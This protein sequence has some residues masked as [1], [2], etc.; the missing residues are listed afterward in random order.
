MLLSKESIAPI[1]ETFLFPFGG[2]VRV[3]IVLLIERANSH[4]FTETYERESISQRKLAERFR[5]APSF[6]YKLLKQYTEKGTLEPK[7]HVASLRD[8]TRSLLPRRGTLRIQN[9]ALYETLKA[10]ADSLTLR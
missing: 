5:V 8:A 7:G 9:D 2:D 1:K 3:L 6:R 10:N 4:N